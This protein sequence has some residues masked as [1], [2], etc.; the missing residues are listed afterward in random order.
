LVVDDDPTVCSAI[1]AALRH[2]GHNATTSADGRQA[3]A[4]FDRQ[5]FD[6]VLSD[7]R[8]PKLDGLT[9]FSTIRERSPT[10]PVIL[11][12]AHGAISEA[13]EA[14]QAGVADYISKP[15]E[16]AE[17]ITRVTRL[18]ER[19]W[20]EREL[21]RPPQN[22][23]GARSRLV[24]TSPAML[25]LQRRID[26]VAPTNATVVI[27]GDSGTGK[28]LVARA[29][30]EGSP[31]SEQPFVV[32]NCAAFPEALIEAELFGHEKGAFTGAAT[33]RDGR[34]KRA[35][36]GTLFFDEVGEIPM[37]MQV[38]LL[39]IVQEG[40]FEPLGSSH[41]VKVNA[42]LVCATHCDLKQRVAEGTF[43]EDLYYRLHVLDI[44]VPPL[45]SRLDDIPLL[46]AHFFGRFSDGGTPRVTPRAWSALM[47]HHYPGNVRELEHAIHHA[48]VL[49]PNGEIDVTH[50]PPS[51]SMLGGHAP[52]Q[53]ETDQHLAVSMRGYERRCLM[54]ALETTKGRKA[55]AARLL[56]ITRK[57]LW[58][59]LRS[60]QITTAERV[61]APKP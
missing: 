14:M 43:R 10:T 12:T 55:E 51:I 32:I 22:L 40:T 4:L 33:K 16:L 34:F 1:D 58:E 20:L 17:L 2:A 28:E 25:E 15:F 39:R 5:Q 30:H 59:K 52:E 27:R 54:R 26:T 53:R 7:V 6:L 21:L 36:G 31:R 50:L 42:R 8:M 9:L 19:L 57:T 23:S 49:S 48:A 24:G 37:G 13:V 61:P 45:S 44:R 60:H 46:V 41:P 56:G 3:L 47:S 38:K 11:M 29:V 18:A 35:D